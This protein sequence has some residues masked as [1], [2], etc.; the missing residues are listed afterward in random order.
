[1]GLDGIDANSRK[2][3]LILRGQ[4]ETLEIVG[5]FVLPWRDRVE[6]DGT[7]SSPSGR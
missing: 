7:R 1:M 6:A 3:R 5:N 2:S 4:D